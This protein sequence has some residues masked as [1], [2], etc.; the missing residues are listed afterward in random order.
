MSDTDEVLD[1]I[2]RARYDIS[3]R[4]KHDVYAYVK[5]LKRLEAQGA[6]QVR[7]HGRTRRRLGPGSVISACAAAR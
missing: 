3:R 2:R 4:Y 5:H 7:K 1:E 6:R